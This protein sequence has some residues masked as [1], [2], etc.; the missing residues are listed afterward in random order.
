MTWLAILIAA[1]EGTKGLGGDPA[2]WVRELGDSDA[3][4]RERAT[5]ALREM[6][7]AA[8]PALE[9]AAASG[10]P[11]VAARARWALEP[12][13]PQRRESGSRAV[14]LVAQWSVRRAAATE[15]LDLQREF[16]VLFEAS[17][18]VIDAGEAVPASA[19]EH[20]DPE[21]ATVWIRRLGDEDW[22]VREEA[23]Q[24]LLGIGE[25]AMGALEGAAESPDPEVRARAGWL[26]EAIGAEGAVGSVPRRLPGAVPESAAIPLVG[27]L[28][29]PPPRT[30]QERLRAYVREW[31]RRNGLTDR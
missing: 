11:E 23:T 8:V 14:R 12:P 24:R 1:Q 17:R 9:A 6:G 21:E 2:H 15:R 31:A 22:A 10:D 5:R 28:F 13:A 19:G 20:A 4:I 26:L 25:G 30:R 18:A 7:D 29:L 27:R 3:R 16:A